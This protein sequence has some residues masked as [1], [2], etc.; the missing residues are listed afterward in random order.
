MNI[1][2]MRSDHTIDFAAEELKKY[3]RMMMPEKGEVPIEHKAD[4]A[5]GFRLGL[6][7]D[8]GLPCECKD[9]S[10]DDIVHIEA[11]AEGGIFAGSNPRSVLFAV[12]RFL[13]LNGCRFFYP[14]PEG[15][16]IPHKEVG[17][18]TYHKLADH[19]LRGHTIEGHPSLE[20]VLNYIDFH[21]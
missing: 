11:D 14:G 12:Y 9:P 3:L 8:F 2:K 18:T 10:L 7:S 1:Y 16:Y 15:E 19:R 5:G 17:P 4:A 20:H 21:A 6:L 13:K